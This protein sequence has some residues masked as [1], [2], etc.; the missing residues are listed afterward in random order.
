MRHF[1][2]RIRVIIFTGLDLLS[3][4]IFFN[5]KY[6]NNTTLIRPVLNKW[7]SR[8][9][10]VPFIFIIIISILGIG[11]FIWLFVNKKIERYTSAFLIAGTAGNLIDRFVYAGVRDFINIGLFNFPIFNLADLMLSIWVAI[12]IIVQLT[13]NSEK[14]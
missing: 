7:I 1:K 8:S 10:P 11:A 3:K 14:K 4:Y 12:R 13:N 9:L 2:L 5:F 6:L